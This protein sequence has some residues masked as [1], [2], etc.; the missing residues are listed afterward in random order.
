MPLFGMSIKGSDVKL[1]FLFDLLR[2]IRCTFFLGSLGVGMKLG[3]T[4]HEMDYDDRSTS[5]FSILI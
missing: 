3:K 4:A 1:S 2:I 5:C